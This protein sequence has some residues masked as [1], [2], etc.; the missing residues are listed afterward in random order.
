VSS[1][2]ARPLPHFRFDELTGVQRRLYDAIVD[3]PRKTVMPSGH[4]DLTDGNGNVVG[5][6]HLFLSPE[7]GDAFQRLGAAVR[8]YSN[9]TPRVLEMAVLIVTGHHNNDFERL[10]HEELGRNWGVSEAEI[11]AIREGSLPELTDANEIAALRLVRSLL[12]EGDV[13]DETW[14]ACIPPLELVHVFE[15]EC[16]V[17]YYSLTSMILRVSRGERTP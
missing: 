6:A 12:L 9:L 13:D 11:A 2:P 1:P 16:L 10:I 14:A 3:G 4:L 8:F 17:A 15:L 5:M 7:I